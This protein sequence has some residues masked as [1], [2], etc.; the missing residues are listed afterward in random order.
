VG[1]I[2]SP[3]RFFERCLTSFRHQRRS[4]PTR[5]RLGATEAKALWRSLWH[6]G[7]NGSYRGEYWRFLWTTLRH[8]PSK[9][10][11]AISLAV[12]GRHLILTTRRALQVDQANARSAPAPVYAKP[13]PT[14]RRSA[15][16]IDART[17]A[18]RPLQRPAQMLRSVHRSNDSRRAFPPA[19]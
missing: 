18:P 9:L 16:S 17:T 2:N 5:K 3:A 13:L 8:H 6:D 14:D 11:N 12:Q 4:P 19:P 7:V 15:R 1:T 10:A